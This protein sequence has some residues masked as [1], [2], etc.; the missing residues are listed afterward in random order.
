MATSKKLNLVFTA[1][2]HWGVPRGMSAN[3][4]LSQSLRENPPDV[5]VLAGDIG[6]AEYFEECIE[7]FSHINCIKALVPGNH[8][9]WVSDTPEKG[10]SYQLYTEILPKLAAKY[11]FHYLDQAPLHL[12]D[13]KLSLVG[14][15]N[16][17]D[18]SW[19][20]ASLKKLFPDELHRL[21]SKRFTRGQHNDFNFV[22]WQYDDK[23]FTQKVVAKLALHMQE[24]VDL[25]HQMIVVTHHP[26]CKAISFPSQGMAPTLDS[27][28]WE[29]LGG[30]DLLEQELIKFKESIAYL[31]SGHTHRERIEDWNGMR[32]YNIGGDYHYKRVLELSWPDREVSSQEFYSSPD[33]A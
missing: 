9:I 12:P 24:V 32:G 5:L 11:K 20:E 31:F 16:W 2:L 33:P 6:H 13:W 14:T 19:S 30:N 26:A 22:R 21:S 15:I 8:D 23:S 25:Q 4:G 29:A 1:D 10:D 7:N 3:L 28:L 18:Y 27:L 17:Y